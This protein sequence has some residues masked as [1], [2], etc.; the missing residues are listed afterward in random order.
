MSY[1][2][3]RMNEIIEKQYAQRKESDNWLLEETIKYGKG[4]SDTGEYLQVIANKIMENN[5]DKEEDE[6]ALYIDKY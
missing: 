2:Y 4:Y 5:K 3:T 6:P 1:D